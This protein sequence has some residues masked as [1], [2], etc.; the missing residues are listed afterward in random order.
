[1]KPLQLTCGSASDII[2]W[3]NETDSISVDYAGISQGHFSV[4]LIVWVEVGGEWDSQKSII[5]SLNN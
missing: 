2:G 4:T 1:M 5:I 3:L